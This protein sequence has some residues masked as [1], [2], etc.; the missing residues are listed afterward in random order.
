MKKILGLDL[1]PNS[2]GWAIILENENMSN[3][4]ILDC[5]V[6]IIP[7]GDEH[8]EFKKGLSIS[9]NKE[10]ALKR[11]ARRMN[12]RYKLRRE[13]LIKL[14][15]K[16]GIFESRDKF[17]KY[18]DE[19]NKR[20]DINNTIALYELRDKAIKE[21]IELKHLAKLF[22]LFNK[23]RGYKS[24]RVAEIE[25]SEDKNQSNWKKE[26]SE[27]D[28]M[29]EESNITIGQF[30]LSNLRK[31][32][33]TKIRDHVFLRSK[34]IEEFDKIWEKQKGYYP[35]VLTDKNYH[36]IRNEIIFYQRP[37]KSQ[38][39]LLSECRF[40]K[41][42]KVIPKSSPL[43]QVFKM[44]QIVN[45]LKITDE[46]GEEVKISAEMRKELFDKLDSA[47]R[48][49]SHQLLKFFDLTPTKD[50]AVNYETLEG[51]TTK[52]ELIKSFKKIDADF[53][54]I[55]QF[56]PFDKNFDTQDYYILWHLLYSVQ[57]PANLK[58]ALINSFGLNKEQAEILARVKF[59]KEYGSLSSKAI[60]KLLPKMQEGY[61]L[62]KACR[63][64]RE[65]SNGNNQQYRNEPITKEEK[66][67]NELPDK[68]ESLQRN[69][70]RNPVVE[71]L[72]NNTI[73][74]VN[75]IV[76]SSELGKPD[77]IRVELA[78]EL[79]SNQKRREI[80]HKQNQERRK[81]NERITKLIKEEF[82]ISNVTTNHLIRYKLWEEADK[83]SVYTGKTI[84]CSDIF[85][86]AKYDIDHII[87][88]SRFFDDSFQNKVLCESK[89]NRDKGN[90]TAFEYMEEKGEGLFESYIQTINKNKNFSKP[91]RKYLKMNSEQIP[92]DFINRQLKETQYISKKVI[93]RLGEICPNVTSTT[94]SVT[95]YLRYNWGL[96]D[97]LRELNLDRFRDKGLTE[98]VELDGNQE[99][100]IIEDWSKR[101]D[102]RHHALDAIV[103][104]FTKQ[105][106]I[107]K[108]NTLNKFVGTN[109]KLLERARY[110]PAP[111][112]NLTQIVNESLSRVLIS[113]RQNSKVVTKNIN[114]IRVGNS[115][116]L[117]QTTWVP[118]GQLHKE[119][120]YGKS[121][122]DDNI[123]V[124]RK[125][126][127][128]DFKSIEDVI[129]PVVREL[130][131]KRLNKFSNDT[132]KAFG[133]LEENP[134]WFN[135]EKSIPL[136]RVR[137]KARPHKLSPIHEKDGKP[138]DFVEPR[139]NH[140]I[141][142]FE[143][144]DGTLVEEIITFWEAVE[145]AINQIEIGEKIEIIRKE[146]PKGYS[147]VTHLKENDMF[148]LG[149]SP[150]EIDFFNP[151]NF[152]LIS[153][154]L[155]R[156]QKITSKDYFFR[157]HLE[158]SLDR[159]TP[160]FVVRIRSLG[161]GKS[162][163]ITHNPV[164]LKINRLGEITKVGE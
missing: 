134:I 120:V 154:Y 143:K 63:W 67:K 80:T 126:I 9:K 84:E 4:K 150:E 142:L 92:D 145:R 55:L 43:F 14:I 124:I 91:K 112:Q 1:G 78:R 17:L 90:K 52:Y 35:K 37:L 24:N 133:N 135:K 8:R 6:R 155:Y 121:Q 70:L 3:N 109:A 72:V 125:K 163:W 5:G 158:T 107:T 75:D 85:D 74:L 146:H 19:F 31:N 82:G 87:P 33:N 28:N 46:Y 44:L 64:L 131:E 34:Y 137:V 41:H 68:I 122:I 69:S 66:L 16:M 86:K 118:R 129:D 26:L 156:V 94:G 162:G 105:K 119:T 54:G 93:E 141:A 45:N 106:Y 88:Q 127:D 128:K 56:D 59:K 32:I 42:H 48:I 65:N 50:Y 12:H 136:K 51:N 101:E 73:S 157:H 2:I 77:E 100:E 99:K 27:I 40:E 132:K 13:N 7:M 110:I 108:L 159:T 10:R 53:N 71:Q 115:K 95:N 79:K 61:T 164:K 148:V 76:K 81:D 89:I 97:V 103:V 149:L 144:P 36:I 138:I 111:V 30:I 15:I 47:S 102:H 21:K 123:S 23:R 153:K 104:A 57:N 29:L 49:T 11:T 140:H 113:F 98:K 139:N 62:D 18:I 114:K 38:K 83:R 22:Y 20:K 60:R 25:E 96:N 160:P 39:G 116:Q 58:T 117:E 130:L 147:F 161:E 151:S 152:P